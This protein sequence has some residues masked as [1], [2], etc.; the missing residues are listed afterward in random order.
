MLISP[1]SFWNRSL[2]RTFETYGECRLPFHFI[3]QRGIWNSNRLVVSLGFIIPV[4]LIHVLASEWVTDTNAGPMTSY[5]GY[6]CKTLLMVPWSIHL[7]FI[8]FIFIF[9]IYSSVYWHSNCIRKNLRFWNFESSRQVV[10][11]VFTCL[12]RIEADENWQAVMSSNE[13]WSALTRIDKQWIQWWAVT[14]IDE[15]SDKHWRASD[16]L[17]HDAWSLMNCPTMTSTLDIYQGFRASFG[18]LK[19]YLSI[20]T[21]IPEIINQFNNI[22]EWKYV[23]KKIHSWPAFKLVPRP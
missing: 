2:G 7:F 5:V 4:Y 8:F 13:N 11:W 1:G 14:R 21:F 22:T 20:L 23:G 19:S 16:E 12:K 3:S 15:L 6:Q 9:S 17:E 10:W 18:L